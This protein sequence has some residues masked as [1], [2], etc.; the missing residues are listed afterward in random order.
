MLA[1]KSSSLED[2]LSHVKRRCEELVQVAEA[3]SDSMR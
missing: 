1:R 3:H 2:T